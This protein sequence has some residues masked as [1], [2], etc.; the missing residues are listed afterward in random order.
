M[1][2][3]R[4]IAQGHKAFTLI[5]MIVIVAVIAILAA[6][7]IPNIAKFTGGGEQAAEGRYWVPGPGV[8]GGGQEEVG[9]QFPLHESPVGSGS[10]EPLAEL[11][12]RLPIAFDSDIAT[13]NR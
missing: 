7:N 11:A 10:P 4:R 9:I 12:G 2:L 3:A 8:A 13:C 1:N 6:V 5:V